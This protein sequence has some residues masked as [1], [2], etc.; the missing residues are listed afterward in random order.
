MNNKNS[1]KKNLQKFEVKIIPNNI[2]IDLE[3]KWSPPT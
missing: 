2:K 3:L 1:E